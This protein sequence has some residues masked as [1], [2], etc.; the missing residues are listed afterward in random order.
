V[1]VFRSDQLVLEGRLDLEGLR[2]QLAP[3][4]QL[5]RRRRSALQ[6]QLALAHQLL[7]VIQWAQLV[8]AHLECLEGRVRRRQRSL[9]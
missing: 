5:P 3:E 7:L 2:L 8:P 4:F 1:S 9:R 6:A